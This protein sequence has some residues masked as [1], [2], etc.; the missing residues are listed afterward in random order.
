MHTTCAIQLLKKFA[1]R[2]R[3][4][5]CD[6][7]LFNKIRSIKLCIFGLWVVDGT[8]RDMN[9]FNKMRLIRN[10][11]K[12]DD[13]VRIFVNSIIRLL[14]TREE[15][16]MVKTS[17][18]TNDATRSRNVLVLTFTFTQLLH[19][20]SFLIS[21]GGRKGSPCSSTVRLQIKTIKIAEGPGLARPSVNQ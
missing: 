18:F 11:C 12:L 13:P 1:C 4:A 15:R 16:E 20:Q 14:L 10:R 17:L 8:D 7:H 9:R 6:M 2:K 21:E 19:P 3:C 5:Q